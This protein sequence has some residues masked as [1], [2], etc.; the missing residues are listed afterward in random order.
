MKRGLLLFICSLFVLAAFPMKAQACKCMAPDIARSYASADHVA[1]VRVVGQMFFAPTGFKRYLGI[2][3]ETFKGC[4][5]QGQWVVVETRS[6]GSACG[7]Q[8]EKKT[9]LLNGSEGG[10]VWGMPKIFVHSCDYNRL[11]SSLTDDDFDYLSSRYNCCGD[12]CAC[13]DGSQ[14]VNCFADPCSVSTCGDP[15]ATCTSNYCGGCNAEWLDARGAVA[16]CSPNLETCDPTQEMSCQDPEL[17]CMANTIDET[18]TCEPF[19]HGTTVGAGYACGGSIG[20]GCA[21]GLFCKGLPFNRLGG[22]GVCTL[23]ECDDW[24][25]EYSRFVDANNQCVS[26]SDCQ[27]ISGTSCG[28]T[29]NLVLSKNADMDAFWSLAD[30]MSADGCSRFTSTCDC[31]RADG[32]KCD[33]GHCRWNYL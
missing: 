9:Y 30:A 24:S 10:F 32:F 2:V 4:L 29:R 18:G 7:M 33:N 1:K 16:D 11:Y 20:V 3:N 22:S 31:P 23:M 19:E 25:A 28:C 12:S 15:E 26:A 21:K 17:I 6:E 8:I 5:D 13:T 27:A 14:P